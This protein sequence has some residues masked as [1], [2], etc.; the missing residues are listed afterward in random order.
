MVLVAISGSRGCIYSELFWHTQPGAVYLYDA[1]VL[2]WALVLP[3]L[4]PCGAFALDPNCDLGHGID[5]THRS[6][7]RKTALDVLGSF[8]IR[9]RIFFIFGNEASTLRFLWPVW[10][11]GVDGALG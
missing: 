11:F 8:L 3:N 7:E 5:N 1:R 9:Y 10:F 2:L 4:D 6:L